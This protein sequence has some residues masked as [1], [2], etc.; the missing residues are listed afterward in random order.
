MTRICRWCDS[1]FKTRRGYT[2]HCSPACRKEEKTYTRMN[3]DL[4]DMALG[5]QVRLG[6]R[7]VHSA[8]ITTNKDGDLV[9]VCIRDKR[10][11][12]VEYNTR[13]QITSRYLCDECRDKA[14]SLGTRPE[15]APDHPRCVTCSALVGLAFGTNTGLD[16]N[17][18]CPGCARWRERMALRVVA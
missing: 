2:Y 5:Q 14:S 12:P 18:E 9:K 8:D 15:A 17:G 10:Q 16:A 13:G 4:V 1:E 7:P 11:F 3:M 6:A